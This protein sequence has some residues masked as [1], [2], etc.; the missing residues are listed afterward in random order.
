VGLMY[1]A[2]FRY[3]CAVLLLVAVVAACGG[4][5]NA[6]APASTASPAPTGPEDRMV[7]IGGRS[8]HVACQGSGSPTVLIEMGAGQ[9]VAAWNG[10]QPE[11]AK[12]HRTCVYERAGTGTSPAGPQPRTAEAVAGDLQ[13]L[14]DKTP[15][16]TPIVIVSH[17]L[18]GMYAQYFAAK[19]A[20]Q[21]SGLVF[22]E[23]RTAE[24]QVGYR[25]NLTAEERAADEAD[26]QQVIKNESFG[27]EI[28]AADT[29]AAQVMAAGSLPNVPVV[30]LTAGVP[31]EG[32]S[33][34]D[35]DFWRATHDHLAAQVP[36]G[37]NTVVDGAEHELWRTHQQAVLDAVAAV[38]ARR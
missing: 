29:S 13:A 35:V 22:L 16:A 20:D 21:L 17:S 26:N 6:A 7:D 9:S 28:E 23:P 31:F 4:G 5:T 3:Q 24:Y 19:H 10:L 32:Q 1:V 30:V 8:L 2:R 34:A 27:P 18:G 37:T 14:I 33:Q 36:G 12:T 15:I 11:L 25:D 38:A